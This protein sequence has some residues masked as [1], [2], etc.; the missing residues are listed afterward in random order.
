MNADPFDWHCLLSFHF[1]KDTYLKGPIR[2]ST[3]ILTNKRAL[4]FFNCVRPVA[5]HSSGVG[6]TVFDV[7]LRTH[8]AQ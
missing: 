6:F 3:L 4:L 8:T 1:T 2:E 7:T 5:Y